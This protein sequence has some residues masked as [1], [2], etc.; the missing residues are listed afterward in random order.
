M[1]KKII[2]L[3]VLPCNEDRYSHITRKV[4]PHNEDR[5][6]HVMRIDTPM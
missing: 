5:Y 6:S 2:F 4:I 1:R 3:E